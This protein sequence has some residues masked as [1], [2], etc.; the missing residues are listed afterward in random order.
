MSLMLQMVEAHLMNVQREISTL[1][2]RKTAIDNEI[3]K[4]TSYLAEGISALEESKKQQSAEVARV[5]T[6][7]DGLS[8]TSQEVQPTFKF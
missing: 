8:V 4:L 7:G 1:N 6:T 2:E 3:D 5:N